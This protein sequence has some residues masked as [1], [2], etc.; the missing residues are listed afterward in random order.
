MI[1]PSAELR[2]FSPGNLPADI[3]AW[4]DREQA[5]LEKRTDSYVAL[6]GTNVVG[7]KIR[8]GKLEVKAL[9]KGPSEVHL[10]GDVIG[11]LEHWTKWSL[12]VDGKSAFN[13][14]VRSSAPVIDLEKKRR[15]VKYA[16]HPSGPQ[17]VPVERHIEA[18][19]NVE[20]T[21]LQIST[22]QCWTFGF[23]AFGDTNLDD[24][25]LSTARLVFAQANVGAAL[26]SAICQSYPAW[27]A[28]LGESN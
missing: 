17:R 9:T 12:D 3:L 18:G 7:V 11:Q 16:S 15:L 20:L 6:K 1:L 2:W 25:L 23:E 22:Q 28:A 8:D 5:G 24:T 13:D 21:A 26:R 19:C 14:A 4:F 10:P 27:I